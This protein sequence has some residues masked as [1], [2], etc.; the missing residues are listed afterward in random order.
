MSGSQ[1]LAVDDYLSFKKMMVKRNTELQ[2]ETI[3]ALQALSERVDEGSIPTPEHEDDFE[4]QM[5]QALALSLADAK[6]EGLVDDYE[7]DVARLQSKQEED[8]LKMALALS[9]QL[10]DERLKLEASNMPPPEPL[11]TSE[12]PRGAPAPLP[13]A[14]GLAPLQPIRGAAPRPAPRLTAAPKP[15][16]T[17]EQAAAAAAAAEVAARAAETARAARQ[18]DE[19]ERDASQ[20]LAFQQPNAGNAS[21][22]E[23][24]GA[25]PSS[26]EPTVPQPVLSRSPRTSGSSSSAELALTS[27]PASSARSLAAGPP[28]CRAPEEA[29][30]FDR[31]S[32]QEGARKG[33]GRGAGAPATAVERLAGHRH[34]PPPAGGRGQRARHGRCRA[35]EPLP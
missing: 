29:A 14:A 6:Q 21:A 27:T 22:E 26:I 18:R 1:V 12:E 28:A 10:E 20:A 2:L 17:P 34:R 31:C 11:A 9:M 25:S 24:R 23:V 35:A 33:D 19:Q 8:D 16:R 30:G 13:Q 3:K 5:E 7:D 32:A 4:A 15:E